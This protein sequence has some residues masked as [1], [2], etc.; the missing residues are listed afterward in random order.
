MNYVR[1][2]WKSFNKC[3]IFYH[4]LDSRCC[5]DQLDWVSGLDKICYGIKE[6][7]INILVRTSFHGHLNAWIHDPS[8]Y[9]QARHWSLITN[10]S[11]TEI[12]MWNMNWRKKCLWLLLCVIFIQYVRLRRWSTRQTTQDR[13]HG[14][15]CIGKGTLHHLLFL[16]TGKQIAYLCCLY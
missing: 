12:K 1:V 13:N 7:K 4:C 6:K 16:A 5:S 10:P 11:L 15:W 14:R 3:V 8:N 2:I 9:L